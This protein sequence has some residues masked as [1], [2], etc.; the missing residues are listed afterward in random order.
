MLSATPD[1]NYQLDRSPPLQPLLLIGLTHLR[2]IE[3]VAL[4]LIVNSSPF[5]AVGIGLDDDDV[6]D[7]L[8]LLDLWHRLL[9]F[10]VA[11]ERG[12]RSEPAAE[13]QQRRSLP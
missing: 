9:P 8:G 11:P 10:L 13:E 5:V 6:G 12:Q 3:P 1:R 4:L 2:S 7:H